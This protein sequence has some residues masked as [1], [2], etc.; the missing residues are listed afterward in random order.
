MF[1]P[2]NFKAP[3]ALK[4]ECTLPDGNVLLVD[5]KDIHSKMKFDYETGKQVCVYRYVRA[6]DGSIIDLMKA[7]I[8]YIKE[9]K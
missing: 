4:A 8:K 5:V 6:E 1:N 9:S 7:K 3:P 2:A